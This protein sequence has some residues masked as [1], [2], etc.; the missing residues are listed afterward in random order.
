MAVKLEI[1][2]DGTA[3]G[4]A[5]HR[6][7]LN[8]FGPA[9]V[10]LVQAY[11]R[12]ASNMAKQAAEDPSTHAMR[13]RLK[14]E[15]AAVDLEITN[16]RP[17]SLAVSLECVNPGATGQ[18]GD[19][20]MDDVLARSADEFLSSIEAESKALQ[21]NS[22]V[23]KYLESLPDGV[24]H[25][26]YTI[27]PNG[28][29]GRTVEIGQVQLSK[30]VEE[31]PSLMEIVG[32]VVGVGFEPGKAE[33]RLLP[34]DGGKVIA[35]AATEAQIEQALK[36]RHEKARAMVLV[37]GTSKLLWIRNGE[38]PSRV[39]AGRGFEGLFERWD[40]LLQRLAK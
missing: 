38:A 5:R 31:M 30:G 12:I 23:R 17:G 4:I 16:M 21:R 14:K 18:T 7:S 32:A 34:E 28:V 6:L 3:P 27:M 35:C 20:F 11:R 36:L 39:S 22:M 2:W 10:N 25:Q 15:V 13:G 9:L 33:V 8:A 24:T 29:P 26:R 19:L 1:E 37:G 40:G